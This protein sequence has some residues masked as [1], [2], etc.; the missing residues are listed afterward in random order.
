MHNWPP[1]RFWPDSPQRALVGLVGFRGGATDRMRRTES[2]RGT[3]VA[4]RSQSRRIRTQLGTRK[5]AYPQSREFDG[6]GR[7][8]RDIDWTDH[9]NPDWHTDPHQHVYG[10]DGSRGGPGSVWP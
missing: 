3:R 4:G 8:V 2:C 10:P 7:P 5:G 1:P 9:G 6:N